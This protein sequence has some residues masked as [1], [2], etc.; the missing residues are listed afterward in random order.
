MKIIRFNRDQLPEFNNPVITIGAF[1]GFHLGHR[2]IIDRVCSI[3]KSRNSDS[4]LISFDPHP[5]KILDQKNEQNYLLNTVEEKIELLSE[6]EL[7]YLI[8]V[9]F[10]FEFS[11]LVAEEYIENFII[12]NFKPQSLVIGFDH[13]FGMNSAGNINMLQEYASKGNFELIEIPKKEIEQDKISSSLIRDYISSNN[14]EYVTKLLGRPYLIKGKIVRGLNIG[15]KLGYPTANIDILEKS[16]L[17]PNPGIYAS[18]LRYNQKSYRGLL[19]IGTRPTIGDK[20]NISIEVHIKDFQEDIYNQEIT[21]EIIQFIREDLKFQSLDDLK[22]QIQRDDIV[23]NEVLDRYDLTMLH[24]KKDPKIAVAI[25]NYN[26]EQILK[27]YLHTVFEHLPKNTQLYVIDNGSSDQSMLYVAQKFP[28]IKRILLG[29]NNGFAGGYNKGINQITDVD[30]ILLLNS[31][32]R[33][34]G[35]WIEPLVQR[36]QSNPLIMACQPKILSDQNP[37]YFEYAGAAGGMIDLLGYSFSRGRMMHQI[38]ADQGQ[39]NDARQIFWASGAAIMVN[40]KMFKSIGGFDQDYFAH[41]EEIDLCWRIQRAGG[42]VWYEPNS[43]VYHLGGGTLDYSNPRKTYLNFKNNLATIF[44]NVPYWYL[45][46]LLPIRLILDMLIACRCL[47][48]GK[49]LL[50]YKIIEAYLVSILSTPY[51]MHKKEIYHQKI[52]R[53]S[54]GPEKFKGVLWGSLFVHYYLF[55]HRVY[56]DIPK[57]YR[58]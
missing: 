42:Q 32:V 44:K 52:G 19:Y 37:N 25:L 46:I 14:F 21:L 3:A 1:D 43:K 16:K 29:Q 15:N 23:I 58:D 40:A 54:I 45:I 47:L 22:R 7:N 30:Y 4:I 33:V 2:S 56:K 24:L 10:N 48:A 35:E 11:Q 27:T 53:N 36:M 12:K 39:Y 55:N 31:D 34:S 18:L 57:H 38:E 26:G 28:E 20:L 51:L 41:Q 9:P 8:L 6:T 17:I 49:W 5:R 50:S 13:R